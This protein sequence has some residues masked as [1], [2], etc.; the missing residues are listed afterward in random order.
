MKTTHRLLAVAFAVAALFATR[1]PLC[2]QGTTFNYQGRLNNGGGLANGSY[3]LTF[4]LFSVSN[5]VGQVGNTLTNAATAVSNGLF[6]VTLDFGNQFTGA[7]R[8]LEVGVRSNGGGAFTPLIPRQPLSA[9]PYALYAMTPGGPAGTNG[10]TGL[11]GPPGA[12]GPVGTFDSSALTNYPTLNGANLFTGTNTVSGVIN[13]TNP[14]NKFSGTF[15]GNGSAVTGLNANN[16][17][18]GTLSLAQ[19]PATVITNGASGV[20]VSGTFTGNG[21]GVTSLNAANLI[22]GTL[23]DARLSTNVAMRVGGNTF[24]GNQTFTGGSALQT[25]DG[26]IN[27]NIVL[28]NLTGANSGYQTISYN[29]DFNGSEVRFNTNKTR[30]RLVTDQRGGS[31]YFYLDTY[32]TNN[33]S[34]IALGVLPNGNVGIGTTAPATTL[35]VAGTVRATAFVGDGSGLTNTPSPKGFVE[36]TTPGSNSWICPAGVTSIS[37]EMWGAGGGGGGGA[38]PTNSALTAVVNDATATPQTLFVGGSG[39]GSG[40]AGAYLRVVIA[41]TSGHAYTINVGTNGT[42]GGANTNG[43]SG[44][45]SQIRDGVTVLATVTGGGGGVKGV[46]QASAAATAG[47][48]AGAG[49]AVG[50]VSLTLNRSG[51]AGA[52][53]SGSSSGLAPGGAAFVGDGNFSS[54]V[55][56]GVALSNDLSAT[57]SSGGTGGRGQRDSSGAYDQ[58]A[59]AGGTGGSGYVLISLY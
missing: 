22:A 13:A 3:D 34:H 1:S 29:G 59:S 51:G 20:N 35:D 36:F 49:G 15:T 10:A 25:S 5:G 47:G 21:A 33:S 39:G 50:G 53:G 32:D 52:G 6:I 4:A 38:S 2:A 23:V 57:T 18:S 43:S 40:G 48:V 24:A 19:L 9:V 54:V 28:R 7:N 12:P 16:F 46:A 45:S 56:G 55:A 30:Y 17:S 11:T 14:A 37:V 44:G 8:W 58:V 31:D 42:A 26:T 41:V 27:G